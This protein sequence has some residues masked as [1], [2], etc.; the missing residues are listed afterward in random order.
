MTIVVPVFKVEQYINK[1]LNSLIVPEE[2]MKKLEVLVINDGTPD[3]SAE[4]AKQFEF[5]YPGTFRV[6]DKENGGHGSAWNL[7]LEKAKGKYIRFLDSDDWYNTPEFVTLL[8]F[9]DTTD[10]DIAITNYNQFYVQRDRFE[11]KP[12][13]TMIPGHIYLAYELN[14]AEQP[15]EIANF[16]RCAYRTKMLQSEPHLFVEKVFYDDIKLTIASVFLAKT[17]CYYDLTIY[18]YLIG[19]TGQTMTP[20]NQKKNY[21]HKFIVQKDIFDYFLIHYPVTGEGRKEYLTRKI[22]SWLLY[23]FYQLSRFPYRASKKY[24]AEWKDYYNKLAPIL[25]FETYPLHTIRLYFSMPFPFY[26][27]SR[28]LKDYLLGNDTELAYD[29]LTQ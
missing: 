19:R 11:P 5:K 16:W 9:L 10:V 20:E 17:V 7:G 29:T 26:Y 2:W 21:L 1:C 18:N 12:I 27:F 6:I 15:W 25:G 28:K 4:M 24:L 23:E 3:R 14:W 8:E 13:S 22:T